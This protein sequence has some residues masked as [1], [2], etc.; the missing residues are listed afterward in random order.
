M[1]SS[2]LDKY[3]TCSSTEGKAPIVSDTKGIPYKAFEVSP[4]RALRVAIRS[5]YDAWRLPSYG[6]L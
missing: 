5:R 3:R 1:N 6:Y 2:L 4:Q